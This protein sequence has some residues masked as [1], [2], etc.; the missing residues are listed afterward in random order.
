MANTGVIFKRCGCR[1]TAGRRLEQACPRLSVRGHGSWHFRASAA[2]LLGRCER[3]RRGGYPSRVAA[4]Q[5][6]NAWLTASQA[7]RTARCWTVGR[8]LRYW[9]S[10]RSH[11]RPTTLMRY[12]RDVETLTPWLG[13]VC[14][15]DLDAHRLRAVFARIAQMTNRHGRPQSG[16]A[17]RHLRGTLRAALNLAVREGVIE[18]NPARHLEILDHRKP[19]PQVWTEPRVQ[20]WRR[21][22]EHPAVAVCLGVSGSL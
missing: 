3:I 2:T 4:G 13:E 5:A 17:M 14:L 8:W 7:Q 19:Y 21:T 6:R 22:G 12:T 9:L 11:L 16:C 18:S 15:A 1:D 20:Q 10:A